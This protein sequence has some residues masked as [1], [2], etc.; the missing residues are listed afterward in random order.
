MKKHLKHIVCIMLSVLFVCLSACADDTGSTPPWVKPEK[1]AD[2]SDFIKANQTIT[3]TVDEHL[4]VLDGAVKGGCTDGTYYYVATDDGQDDPVSSIL[5]YKIS[6]KTLVGTYGNI[7]GEFND[8]TYNPVT[9]EIIAAHTGDDNTKISIFNAETMMLKKTKTMPV[10]TLSIAYD[11]YENCYWVLTNNLSIAKLN[12]NFKKDGEVNEFSNCGCAVQGMDVDSTY[13]YVLTYETDKI[14][15]YDKTVALVK[16]IYLPRNA[17]EPQN[18]CHVGENF[19]IGYADALGGGKVYKSNM[20]TYQTPTADPSSTVEPENLSVELKRVTN[21]ERGYTNSNVLCYVVQGGCTDGKYYYA[22]II[23][24][25]KTVDEVSMIRKYDLATGELVAT[26]DDLK[27]GHC[28]DMTYNPNTNEIIVSH[29]LPSEIS[30]IISVFD[31]KD[32]TL[33]ETVELTV[34]TGAI[35]YDPYQNCFIASNVNNV[36]NVRYATFVKYDLGFK[37]IGRTQANIG[38]I[39][40]KTTQQIDIDSKYIYYCQYKNNAIVVYDKTT[41][42]HVKDIMLPITTREAEHVFH[43][44]ETLYVGYYDAPGGTLYKIDITA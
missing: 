31:A 33:K 39:T 44:G 4:N 22:G 17:S 16:E 2:P 23:Q 10:K 38:L 40:Q 8:L 1:S 24:S 3:F 43:V 18:L 29:A 37:E 41:G 7:K 36:D 35:S 11:H 21:V 20:T 30:N 5:K 15:V 14:L 19:Y 12:A 6:N 27:V 28:N 25:T 42:E 34:G 32:F 26:Y 13:I 9:K